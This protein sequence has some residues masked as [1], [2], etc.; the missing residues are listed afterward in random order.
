MFNDFLKQIFETS[1]I[2]RTPDPPFGDPS[3]QADCLVNLIPSSPQTLFIGGHGGGPPGGGGRKRGSVNLPSTVF[4]ITIFLL[5]VFWVLRGSAA[6]RVVIG[7]RGLTPPCPPL[8]LTYGGRRSKGS[9]KSAKV[10]S[11]T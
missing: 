4:P 7:S 10:T 11:L 1:S 3:R 5:S 2:P 9:P 6:A 8:L